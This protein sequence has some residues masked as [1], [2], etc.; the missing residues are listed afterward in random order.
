MKPIIVICLLVVFVC[1][2]Y[3]D[4]PKEHVSRPTAVRNPEPPASRPARSA[5]GNVPEPSTMAL[6]IAG[7]IAGGIYLLHRKK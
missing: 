3:C 2:C 1:G 7:L 5:Q 6:L 4:V